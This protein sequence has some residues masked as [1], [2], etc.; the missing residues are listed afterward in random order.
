MLARQFQNSYEP[1]GT[2]T[3]RTIFTEYGI[4]IVERARV[5]AELERPDKTKTTLVLTEIEPGVFEISVQATMPG[6]YRF[7]VLGTGTTLQG[8]PFTREQIVTGV[9]YKGGNNPPPICINDFREIYK[10]LFRL[11]CFWI[12]LLLIAFFGV[13]TLIDLFF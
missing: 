3:L 1:G 5:R 12:L 8:N 6:I 10:L 13:T 7:K 11:P 4:P 2:L 9:V